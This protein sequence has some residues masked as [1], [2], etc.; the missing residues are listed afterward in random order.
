MSQKEHTKV[1]KK[2]GEHN[3]QPYVQGVVESRA[4]NA[5]FAMTALM[6][7]VVVNMGRVG[8]LS[9]MTKA[10][11]RIDHKARYKSDRGLDAED[12]HDQKGR[13][14][15]GDHNGKHLVRGGEENGD[16]CAKRDHT[17][18]VQSRRGGREATLRHRA[19]QSAEKGSHLA[20]ATNGMLHGFTRAMLNKF[21]K[22]IGEKQKGDQRQKLLGRM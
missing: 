17:P 14:P 16:E 18:R 1:Q 8:L 21:H 2:D 6:L 9:S 4:Q 19:E 22:K 15:R 5:A 10:K 3:E 7:T 20:R 13:G 11:R 12:L